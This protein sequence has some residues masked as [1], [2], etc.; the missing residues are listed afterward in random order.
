MR[1]SL[2]DLVLLVHFALAAFI[3]AGIVCIGL[4]GILG[5]GWVR[6]RSFRIVHLAAICVV[7]LEAIFGIACPLTVLEDRLRGGLSE[8]GFIARWVSHLLYYDLPDW[9]FTVAY[10]TAA[11]ATLLAWRWMPPRARRR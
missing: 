11:A 8:R 10:V 3:V 1:L 4:G 6:N 2:A 5:W 9:V 7:A